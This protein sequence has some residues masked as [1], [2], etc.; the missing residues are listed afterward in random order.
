MRATSSAFLFSDKQLFSLNWFSVAFFSSFEAIPK[1][2]FNKYNKQI[3]ISSSLY[4]PCF[5]LLISGIFT[6]QIFNKHF[7]REKHSNL[8]SLFCVFSLFSSSTEE[9]CLML[10]LCEDDGIL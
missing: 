4:N 6:R 5:V 10:G 2:F 1:V 8:F 3:F 9:G 7:K